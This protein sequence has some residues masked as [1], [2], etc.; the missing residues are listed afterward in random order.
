MKIKQL[1]ISD[2]KNLDAHLIHNSDIIALIGNNGSGKSNILEAIS[3]IFRSLYVAK[4]KVT[5]NYF[6][7]YITSKN[8]LVKIEK[9]GN[10][11]KYHLDEVEKS[12]LEIS[13][14]LPQKVIGIYSGEET[15]LYDDCFG[16]FYLEFVTN[17][18]KAQIQKTVYSDL[19]KMLFL[20]SFYWNISLLCLLISDS[21]DN[22][23]FVEQI[24]KIQDLDSI[25]IKID[26]I[27]R[28]YANYNDNQALRLVRD[29]DSKSEYTLKE[30]KKLLSEKFY[31]PLDV[32]KYLY[33]AY[34]P[35]DAKIIDGIIIEFTNNLTVSDL[36]EGEKKLL[37][38]KGALEFAGQEDSIFILDEPDSHIHI[39][40]K[41]QITNS[42]I[43][44]LHNRQIVITTHSPTLTQCVNDENVYMLSN[45]KIIDKNKQEIIEEVTGDFWNK[46]QQ[47]SFISSKKPIILLV[48]GKHD[49]EHIN[50]AFE[51]L[52][53]EYTDLK[54]DIFYMNSACNIPLMMTGLRTSEIEYKKIFIGIFDDDQTGRTELSNTT[55][56]F[57][58]NQNKKRH[59]EGYYAFIYPK[60]ENHKSS[61]F[62]V[63]NFFDSLHL[64]TAYN[65]AL[66]ELSGKF[67]GK[68]I[69][70]ISEEI[71]E[72]AK[73]KLFESSR[74]FANKEDFKNFRKLFD[75][76]RDIK[77]KYYESLIAIHDPNPINETENKNNKSNVKE[78]DNIE[79]YT[80]R[81]NT[82]VEAR[83]YNDK[84]IVL[85]QGSKLSVD[86]VD[87]Y[88]NSIERNKELKKIADLQENCW[89]LKEDKTFNSV[90]GAINYATGGNMNGWAHWLIKENK[91]P[92]ETIREK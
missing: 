65:L 11:I 21:T 7:E 8:N 63:E 32:F 51:K 83:Y 61:I 50:N 5:F 10:E 17:I 20:N 76:I 89:V 86:V 35:K 31:T 15:R 82:E 69:E 74:S 81:R 45:G 28:N 3:H 22:Q 75:L 42:F 18:N 62:T 40:N 24:L 87:S 78:D 59:K 39:N 66:S 9:I 16:P 30:F 36:S 23:K 53:D 48:E 57:P 19:P 60:H 85:I 67:T 33:L 41:E 27:K 72:K 80:K 49:K 34:T 44:Y 77:D 25:K 47:N 91:K 52:K 56:K 2:Y 92:L 73:Q 54:F 43:D 88:G 12:A 79:I 6:I 38:I 70:T 4:Y 58:D 68:S 84:K 46:H 90:S 71:R 64:E 37:L 26:F 1:K 55:C 14:Y 13:N 29:I